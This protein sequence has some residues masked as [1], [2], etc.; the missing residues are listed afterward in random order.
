MKK[1]L[2]GC[3][4]F[5]IV[6]LGFA[7][8]TGR[9]V[10]GSGPAV[11]VTHA[12]AH[13]DSQPFTSSTV[14]DQAAGAGI[15]HSTPESSVSQSAA[16]V[17]QTTPGTKPPP[18][19]VASFDGLGEGF[20]GPQGTARFRNPSDNS[21]AVGPDHIVQTVN[22]RMAVFTKKGRRFDTTGVVLYGPVPTNN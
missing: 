3:G 12:V 10:Q 13:D 1:A 11:S 9:S 2:V 14:G 6:I 21:L 20:E 5:L 19:I 15:F 16:S 18:E 4:F 17:E 8:R 7:G 22:S